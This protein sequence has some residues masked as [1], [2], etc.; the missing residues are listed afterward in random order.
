MEAEAVP[1]V[2]SH[3]NK[4]QPE[5]D[6]SPGRDAMLDELPAI[7]PLK[8]PIARQVGAVGDEA[9]TCKKGDKV[10]ASRGQFRDNPPE[11]QWKQ[12]TPEW[13]ADNRGEGMGIQ[14]RQRVRELQ[15][16]KRDVLDRSAGGREMDYVA[17][18]MDDHH[19]QPGEGERGEDEQ[20][21]PGAI[22]EVQGTILLPGTRAESA[23]E[24]D[25][26]RR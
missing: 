11:Q 22:W 9:E 15:G 21:L 3:D 25:A 19:R 7:A 5:R 17:R 26:G 4:G 18:F 14:I 8:E 23:T 12:H 1:D 13:P 24:T 10:G 16:V 20:G 6:E 2:Q